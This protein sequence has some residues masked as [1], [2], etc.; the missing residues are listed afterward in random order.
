MSRI[1]TRSASLPYEFQNLLLIH[2]HNRL[3]GYKQSHKKA[4]AIQTITRMKVEWIFHLSH[5]FSHGDILS[6]SLS[7]PNAAMPETAMTIIA[8]NTSIGNRMIT[9]VA[10]KMTKTDN[11]SKHA[12]IVLSPLVIF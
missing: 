4:A 3:L 9:T 8:S 5:L 12:T 1:L 10:A 11:G 6:A 2:K 7:M